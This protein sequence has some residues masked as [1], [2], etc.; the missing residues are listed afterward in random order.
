MLL[1]IFRARGPDGMR[2]YF[3]GEEVTKIVGSER[4]SLNIHS[5]DGDH[6]NWSPE[7]KVPTHQGCHS[8]HSNTGE[9]NPGWGGEVNDDELLLMLSSGYTQRKIAEEIGRSQPW[10]SRYLKY[11]SGSGGTGRRRKREEDHLHPDAEKLRILL[12]GEDNS[13]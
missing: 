4:D 11:G 8:R 12:S 10:V 1:E 5:L 6:E 7:N 2:C 9:L 13:C 3:C